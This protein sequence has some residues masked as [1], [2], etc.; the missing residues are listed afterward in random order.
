MR[1]WDRNRDGEEMRD[2]EK[3]SAKRDRTMKRGREKEREK[4]RGEREHLRVAT[5]CVSS[6]N[7]CKPRSGGSPLDLLF[8]SPDSL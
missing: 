8:S 3:E 7:E 2:E 6:L 4:E 5:A 1:G